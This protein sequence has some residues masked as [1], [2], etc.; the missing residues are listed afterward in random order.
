[1]TTKRSGEVIKVNQDLL[2]KRPQIWMVALST[3]SLN[4]LITYSFQSIDIQHFHYYFVDRLTD[5]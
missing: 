1:M 3:A 4:F 2:F 5:P